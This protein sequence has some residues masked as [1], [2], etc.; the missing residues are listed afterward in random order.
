M[1]ILLLVAKKND[2]ILYI[3][4]KKFNDEKIHYSFFFDW[5]QLYQCQNA[6]PDL[7]DEYRIGIDLNSQKPVTIR[8]DL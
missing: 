6:N 3:R 7:S 1:L 8:A 5:A 2:K 4:L